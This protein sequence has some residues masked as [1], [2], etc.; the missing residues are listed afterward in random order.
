M[1][2]RAIFKSYSKRHFSFTLENNNDIIFEE[3]NP[4]GII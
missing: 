1:M 2:E 3:I 4:F